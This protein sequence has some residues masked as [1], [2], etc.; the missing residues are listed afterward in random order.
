MNTFRVA[1]A[2][3][4]LVVALATAVRPGGDAV[5]A[6][7]YAAAKKD[8]Q[9]TIYGPSAQIL[10]GLER[11]FPKAFPGIEIRSV[12]LDPPDLAARII[13]EKRA[14]Q[15]RADLV[16]GSMR[17]YLELVDRG[18]MSRQDYPALGVAR[19][20]ILLDGRM[21]AVHNAVFAHGYNT[22][23]VRDRAELPKTYKDLLDPKWKG[24]LAGWEFF[25]SS[26]L[27]FWGMEIGESAVLEYTR[28]LKNHD[29]LLT[30]AVSNVVGTGERAIWLFGHVHTILQEQAKGVPLDLFFIEAH[31]GAQLGTLIPDGARHVNAARLVVKFLLSD[32]GKAMLWQY[33]RVGDARPGATSELAQVIADRGGRVVIETEDNFR[34]RA[35]LAGKIRKVLVGQ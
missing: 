22:N 17:D 7:L 8:S 5:S 30:R 33:A 11:E 14:G 1:I 18:L 23:L 24:R 10:Q 27:A 31:G 20:R 6:G 29:V 9:V 12:Q 34:P 16:M 26:G 13:T 28:S 25:V 19:D 2:A 15:P 21:V 3:C 32:P 4:S 35:L